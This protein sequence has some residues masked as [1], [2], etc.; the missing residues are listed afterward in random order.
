[1]EGVDDSLLSDTLQA[2][3]LTESPA[4]RGERF[5]GKKK[6]MDMCGG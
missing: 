2:I 6:L 5:G 1:M 3:G 4:T